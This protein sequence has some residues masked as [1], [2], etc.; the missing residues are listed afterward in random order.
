MRLLLTSSANYVL[1]LLYD[2]LIPVGMAQTHRV[3]D[4][5]RYTNRPAHNRLIRAESSH[6]MISMGR[7][8]G[9]VPTVYYESS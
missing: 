2:I 3:W 4:E 8:Y 1:Y 9:S 5:E 6:I 7:V